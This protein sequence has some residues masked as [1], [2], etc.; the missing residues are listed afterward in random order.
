MLPLSAAEPPHFFLGFLDRLSMQLVPDAAVNKFA[1]QSL[2]LCALDAESVGQ[3][4]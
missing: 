3:Y 1:L 4:A 2:G